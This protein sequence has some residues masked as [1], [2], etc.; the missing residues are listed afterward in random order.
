M[1]RIR[2][3][4]RVWILLRKIYP[5]GQSKVNIQLLKSHPVYPHRQ[6]LSERKIRKLNTP[7][8]KYLHIYS[9]S[10]FISMANYLAL[11]KRNFTVKFRIYCLIK[12]PFFNANSFKLVKQIQLFVLQSKHEKDIPKRLR[13]LLNM[14]MNNWQFPYK[15]M[16]IFLCQLLTGELEP[17]FSNI[18]KKWKINGIKNT[19]GYVARNINLLNECY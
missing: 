10:K 15:N 5:H 16:G 18:W 14:R 3:R 1:I 2:I 4:V 8:P 11:Q 9:G 6:S 17:C 13:L 19:S 12:I 7:T